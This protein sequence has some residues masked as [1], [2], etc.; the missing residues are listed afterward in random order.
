MKDGTAPLDVGEHVGLALHIERRYFGD[1]PGNLEGEALLGLVEAGRAYDPGRGVPFAGFAGQVIAFRLLAA[2]RRER[3]R[4]LT[5]PL[6][7]EDAD[8]NERERPEAA[9]ET[10]PGAEV[11]AR[12]LRAA[13]AALPARERNVVVLRFWRGATLDQVAEVLGLSRQRVAQVEA[14]ALRRLRKATCGP[15]PR[16]AR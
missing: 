13:V 12:Q 1:D 14:Q 8:G 6:N 2:V 16:A 10:D 11:L 15:R 5:A 4:V 9:V 7:P 3:A